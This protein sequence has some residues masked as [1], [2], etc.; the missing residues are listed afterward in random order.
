M[1][2][3][4]VAIGGSGN[5]VWR[6]M[7]ENNFL[8]RK[9]KTNET[10]VSLSYT[11]WSCKRAN[12]PSYGDWHKLMDL[13]LREGMTKPEK[14]ERRRNRFTNV[15]PICIRAERPLDY[16]EANYRAGISQWSFLRSFPAQEWKQKTSSEKG[17]IINRKSLSWSGGNRVTK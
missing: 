16:D 2:R 12:E 9:R 17:H 10:N 15:P 1:N 13:K 11:N 4:Q 7:E 5:G 14:H 3:T 8:G 6:V